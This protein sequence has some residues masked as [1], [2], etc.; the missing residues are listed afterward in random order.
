MKKYS[1][2]I[3]LVTVMLLAASYVQAARPLEADTNLAEGK[4]ANGTFDGLA[5]ATDGKLTGGRATSGN[6]TDTPQYLSIDLGASMYLDR[7]KIYWDRDALSNDF[8]VKTSTDSRAWVEEASG[9][10]AANGVADNAS[11]T[12]ALSISLKRAMASS[13]YVQIMIPAGTRVKNAS[14]NFVKIAEVQVFPAVG[15]KFGIDDIKQYA[16]TDSSCVIVYKTS[17]GAASGSA[18]YGTE[19]NK[20]DKAAGNTESGA[21]NSVVIGGLKP[22]TTYFYRIKATDFYG[23]SVT[24]KVINFTTEKEN[25]ALNKKVTG[26]FTELPP[27]ENFMKAGTAD[28]ILSR[29]TDG[30][31]GYFTSMATSGPVPDADQYVVIDLGKTYKIKSIQ[32]YWRQLAYPERLSVQLSS[33]EKD[34]TT[35]ADAMNAGAGAFARSDAGDPM[36]IANAAGGSGRYVK[37]LVKKGSPFFHKHSD[38]NFVQLMEVRVFAE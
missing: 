34:W 28:E 24:S 11:K 20:L 25:V 33:N 17:I 30:G 21:V 10:D 38:W 13:R 22:N 29:V 3:I 6:I 32:S 18:S 2:F 7:V 27:K 19:P 15:Q 16:L 37:L 1:I 36:R 4:S 23:N 9:L 35:I 26:T 14:G 12:V 31:T 5:F 8:T